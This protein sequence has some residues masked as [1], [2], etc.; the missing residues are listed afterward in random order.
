MNPDW[1][2]AVRDQATVAGVPFL[3][4]QWG[5]ATR[6]RGRVLDGRTWD[7]RPVGMARAA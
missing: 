6:G 4:L 2:R 7:E 3:F 1:V 5:G